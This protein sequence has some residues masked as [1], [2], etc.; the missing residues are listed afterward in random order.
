VFERT[1]QV[2]THGRYLVAP[3]K[4]ASG[5]LLVGFHGYGEAAETQMARLRAI[6][7]VDAWTTVS[8][9]GLHRF[10]ERRTDSVVASWMTRQDRDLTIAD[11]TAYVSTV[12]EAEWRAQGASAGVV[13]AGFSQ[14]VAM[15]FRAAMKSPR[16]VLGLIAA[17]GDVPPEIDGSALGR[18]VSALLCR[19]D[20][21]KWYTASKFQ[22]DQIRLLAAGVALTAH[23]FAGGH[24][25]SEQ[26][27]DASARFLDDRTR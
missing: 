17:G 2:T 6:P 16:P 25:W 13:Y 5:P 24:E 14:G 15:A 19:G 27:V 18:V 8:I 23:A 11:N 26:V 1:I 9:Q 20:D 7:G 22:Q 10:Y 3:A 12:V 21:D 4:L